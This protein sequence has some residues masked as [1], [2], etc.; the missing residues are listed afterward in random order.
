MTI[1]EAIEEFWKSM[2][3]DIVWDDGWDNTRSALRDVITAARKDGRQ[4]VQ[5]KDW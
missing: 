2:R 5:D 3:S 1:E 4:D